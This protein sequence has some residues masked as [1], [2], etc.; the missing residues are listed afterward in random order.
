MDREYS[1]SDPNNSNSL[2]ATLQSLNGQVDAALKEFH[3]NLITGM[4]LLTEKAS[5]PERVII[6]RILDNVLKPSAKKAISDEWIAEGRVLVHI[7]GREVAAGNFKNALAMFQFI[8]CLFPGLG[9]AWVG[10][11]VCEEELGNKDKAAAIFTL[12]MDSL[13]NNYFVHLHAAVFFS[14]CGDQEKVKEITQRIQQML[15]QEQDS[16]C[17]MH[18]SKDVKQILSQI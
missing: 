3:G 12:G 5:Q 15:Y 18:V 2:Q 10:L 13:P 14:A 7:A 1:L 4:T 17:S 6:D 9:S 16:E 11:A 8:I